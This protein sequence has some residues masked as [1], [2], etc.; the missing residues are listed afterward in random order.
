MNYFQSAYSSPK[1]WTALNLC[2]I[3]GQLP[4][5]YFMNQFFRIELSLHM[6]ITTLLPIYYLHT[7]NLEP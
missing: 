5:L 1:T 6:Y 7:R 3:F 4:I 2:S